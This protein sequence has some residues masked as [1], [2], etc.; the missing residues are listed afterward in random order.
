MQ[1]MPIRRTLILS[2]C[3]AVFLAAASTARSEVKKV[4]FAKIEVDVEDAY[5][6]DAAFQAMQKSF[7]DAAR[8]KNSQ[9]LFDLVGPTF[10]WTVQGALVQD[11]DF[12]RGALH[13][14]KVVFGFRE[15]GKDTDGGAQ[16]GPSWSVLEAFA[17]DRTYYK[18]AGNLVCGPIRGVAHDDDAFAE[19]QN[20]I[21]SDDSVSW[22]FTLADKT[23]VTKGPTDNTQVATISRQISPVLSVYPPDAGTQPAPPMTHLEVLIPTG[24][25][26]WIPISAARPLETDRLCYA[27]TPNRQWKI[28]L[29]DQAGEAS[30]Q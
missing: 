23:T 9:A 14:F 10:V 4:P 6:P 24:K 12:G 5:K 2:S 30:E 15:V 7:S 19:A 25:T 1:S 28:V 8:N 3:L 20:K 21:E 13:N 22:Y 26:G 11:Y 16:D 27:A 18:V 17:N 29:F